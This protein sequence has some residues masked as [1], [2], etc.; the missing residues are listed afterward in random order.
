MLQR[1]KWRKEHLM[2]LPPPPLLNTVQNY[3]LSV[4][5]QKSKHSFQWTDFSKN[6]PKSAICLVYN[7]TKL[8]N[9]FFDQK[10]IIF[11]FP[12][13]SKV[14]LFCHLQWRRMPLAALCVFLRRKIA[15]AFVFTGITLLWEQGGPI[16]MCFMGL[17]SRSAPSSRLC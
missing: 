5:R 17:F 12:G 16:G 2:D 6:F 8:L 15:I 4:F 10:S 3:P 1:A 14:Y 11:G 9:V 7:Q 13:S